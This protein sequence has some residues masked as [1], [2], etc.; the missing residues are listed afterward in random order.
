MQAETATLREL[1]SAAIDVAECTMERINTP[2]LRCNRH[3]LERNVFTPRGLRALIER[4]RAKFMLINVLA[5]VAAR[6]RSLCSRVLLCD[7]CYMGA[8]CQAAAQETHDLWNATDPHPQA[9]P[10]A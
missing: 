10:A 4:T 7:T 8:R 1:Q 6:S 9:D 5:V 3:S 2:S